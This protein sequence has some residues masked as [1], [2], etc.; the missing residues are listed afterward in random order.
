MHHEKTPQNVQAILL[1][2]VRVLRDYGKG[3][4]REPEWAAIAAVRL[5]KAVKLPN[6]PV[7]RLCIKRL[8]L[9][10]LCFPANWAENDIH[11]GFI[12]SRRA[13][14]PTAVWCK[15]MIHLPHPVYDV[16]KAVINKP[17][18]PAVQPCEAIPRSWR[19][20]LGPCK[21]ISAQIVGP[22]SGGQC[23]KHH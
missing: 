6:S 19:S 16:Q 17:I 2:N 5:M 7:K 11:I 22:R 13:D 20:H 15:D 4:Q 3:N 18:N 10:A 14:F 12:R 21:D 1:L 23:A 9:L 8:V